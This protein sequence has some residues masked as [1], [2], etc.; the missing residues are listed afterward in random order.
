MALAIIG[1]A[2]KSN[3]LGKGNGKERVGLQRS[4]TDILLYT[5]KHIYVTFIVLCIE[6]N[7]R[8]LLSSFTLKSTE[9]L[10][11]TAT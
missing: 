6:Q 4:L 7:K 8:S 2:H 3:Q 1:I 11:K 9:K 10:K 5:N